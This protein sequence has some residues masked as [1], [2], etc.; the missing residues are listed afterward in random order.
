MGG[1]LTQFVVLTI[2]AWLI[3][4]EA[5]GLL[6]PAMVFVGIGQVFV[7]GGF[8]KAIIQ[9]KDL[10]DLHLSTAFW[11]S[12]CVGILLT[13][14]IAALATPI[15]RLYNMP[16]LAPILRWLGLAIF[17][18][19]LGMTQMGILQRQMRFKSLA[20]RNLCAQLVGGTVAVIF[21]SLGKGV[22]SLVAL[23]LTARSV[24]VVIVWTASDFRPSFNFSK[25]HFHD[26]FSFG[27]NVLGINL[28]YM[29]SLRTPDLLIP[30]LLGKQAAGYYFLAF[31]LVSVFS[32]VL[33]GA[34][35]STA[36]PTFSK[37]QHE[38][39][40]LRRAYLM[41]IRISSAVA[42]PF[43]AGLAVAAPL[44]IP[45]LWGPKWE[46][47]IAVVQILSLLGISQVLTR[48]TDAAVMALGKPSWPLKIV[49]V[50]TV[51]NIISFLIVYKYGIYA[52]AIAMACSS[53]V[54]MPLS[55]WALNRILPLN[56]VHLAMLLGRPLVCVGIMAGVL[57]FAKQTPLL[58]MNRYVNLAMISI[59]GVVAY[60]LSLLVIDRPIVNEFWSMGTMLLKKTRHDKS[61]PTPPAV[62][63]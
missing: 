37:L 1:Q 7:E 54:A 20:V 31:R 52:I 19:S 10:E 41:A 35:S 17:I 55:F 59:I 28:L 60:G 45:V 22:W 36:L 34:L 39:E 26:L 21:A 29:A 15:A 30:M 25:K 11:T 8:N 46:P 49:L 50:G 27:A 9:R 5:F 51:F 61:S 47:A 14:T 16:E 6:A 12:V 58:E 33:V 62:S 53:L 2:L 32:Q 42:L 63:Q 40:R 13:A 24:E 57:I 44:F 18:G 4:P 43:F 23:Q 48:F 38:P 3:A 56:K